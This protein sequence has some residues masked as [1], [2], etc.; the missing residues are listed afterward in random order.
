MD[1]KELINDVFQLEQKLFKMMDSYRLV[2]RKCKEK[3]LN[4]EERKQLSSD[5]HYVFERL[6][7]I[8]GNACPSLTD[9]DLLFCCLKKTGIESL[10]A[11]RCIGSASRQ[12]VNQ[13][14]YRIKKKMKEANC[15]YI[16]DLIF[17]PED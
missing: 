9:E 17:P 4:P 14:K 13:R 5:I 10:V 8:T 11:G 16:F 15:D 12:S 7:R 3:C 6:I 1:V 2:E